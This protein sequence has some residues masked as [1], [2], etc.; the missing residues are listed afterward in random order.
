[1]EKPMQVTDKVVLQ[2]GTTPVEGRVLVFV[3]APKMTPSQHKTYSRPVVTS[4]I[5]TDGAVT[6]TLADLATFSVPDALYRAVFLT[7]DAEW[8]EIWNVGPA[9]GPSTFS[10]VRAQG[11]YVQDGDYGL[12]PEDGLRLEVLSLTQRM[13][14]LEARLQAANIA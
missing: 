10:Q 11:Q 14:S 8:Y 12:A 5:G 7:A 3:T 1:M 9:A 2:D 13:D 4:V 6:L